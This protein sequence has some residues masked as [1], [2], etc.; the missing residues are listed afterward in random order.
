[1]DKLS[2]LG[3][4]LSVQIFMTKKTFLATPRGD[5]LVGLFVVFFHG[6]SIDV[7]C[8]V[9]FFNLGVVGVQFRDEDDRPLQFTFLISFTFSNVGPWYN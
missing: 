2:I 1:M 6:Q 9:Q 5:L 7:Y 4:F 3:F 8:E